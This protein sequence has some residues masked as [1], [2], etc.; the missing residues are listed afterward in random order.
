MYEMIFFKKRRKSPK[1]RE[2]DRLKWSSSDQK[3]NLKKKYKQKAPHHII[4]KFLNSR[5]KKINPKTFQSGV[6]VTREGIGIRNKQ[7]ST[8]TLETRRQ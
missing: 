2:V 6:R 7:S 3:N 1:L 5:G 4:V 8:G